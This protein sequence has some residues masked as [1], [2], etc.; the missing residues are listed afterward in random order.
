MKKKPK[1]HAFKD[2]GLVLPTI[3][4]QYGAKSKVLVWSQVKPPT[5][6]SDQNCN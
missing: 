4:L 3:S 6:L 1:R 5:L 2:A